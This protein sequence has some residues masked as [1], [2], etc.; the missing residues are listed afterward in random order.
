[1]AD[2]VSIGNATLYHGDCLSL[3]PSVGHVD[4]VITDPPFNAG[5]DFQNDSMPADEWRSFCT[6]VAEQ[7]SSLSPVNVV[8]EV[9]K[10][11]KE[12]RAALDA[13]LRYRWALALNYTNAMRN[14]AVG[15]S[16]FGLALW[17]GEKCFK[18]F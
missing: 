8:I 11:D 17:Y 1:M 7:I 9:G 16:N 18:R 12:M 2:P 3:L 13:R 5:K 4:A 14:G 15:Y 6:R 10:N